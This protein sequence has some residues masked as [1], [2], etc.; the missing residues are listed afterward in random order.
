MMQQV[1]SLFLL[2]GL[3]LTGSSRAAWEV[4]MTEG[5]T[6]VSRNIYGLHMTILMICVVIGLIV[7]GVMFYSIFKHRKSKG[8]V[9]H[10]FHESTLVEIVW[11]SIPFL[12]LVLMAIPATKTLVEIYNTDEADIDIKITGYQWKWQYEYVGEDVSFFSNLSTP[13]E[14]ILNARDKNP[15]YLLEV[16]E[17]LVVPVGKKVRFLVTAADVIHSWWVPAL[18]VKR[19]AIPGFINEAWTN[20]DVPGTYRGQ[21]AELCGKNHAYMPIVV[22]AKSQ[23]D[24]DAWLQAKKDEAVKAR[25][26]TDK[27]WTMAELMVRGE[28]TYNKVCAVCHQPNGTGMPPIFP[29]LKGSPMA[30]EADQIGAHVDIVMNGKK[31]SAMQAFAGQLSEVDLAAVITFE[32]NAWGNDTGEMVTPKEIVDYK[33]TGKYVKDQAKQAMPDNQQASL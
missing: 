10:Q 30:T 32:R 18:A 12:I 33:E 13:Q 4:N 29:A 9:A 15:N 6:A 24:Y 5:V 14:Q 3:A 7:F 19:D 27:S 21:C 8:A 2:A 26:L 17:P 16:D 28:Q 11:T 22:E 25:E 23:E 31:G 20:I 1:K